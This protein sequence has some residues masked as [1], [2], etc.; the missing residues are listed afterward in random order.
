MKLSTLS[1][2]AIAITLPL[3]FLS[4][5]SAAGGNK[6]PVGT[7]TRGPYLQMQSSTGV[8]VRWRTSSENIG[9]I[10][11]GTQIDKLDQS[12]EEQKPTTEHE[13]AIKQLQAGTQYYYQVGEKN[14]PELRKGLAEQFFNTTP[15]TN[16]PYRVWVIGDAG[17]ANDEQVKV[18]DAFY[19][20]EAKEKK[21]ADFWLM[22]GDNA[23][24]TG[25]DQEYQKAVFD[26][27]P[28]I[29]KRSTLFSTRGNHE[30][31]R[32]PSGQAVYYDIFSFP[33]G[34]E[35]G[36]LASGTE[37][38][39]SFNYGPVHYVCLDSEGSDRSKTGAMAQ[40]LKKDLEN[41][42]KPWT[43][44]FWHHPPYTKGS[45]DSD[46]ESQLVE[47]RENFLPLLESFGV[48][49]VLSGHSHSYERSYFMNG[50]FGK[51]ETFKATTHIVQSGYGRPKQDAAYQKQTQ[52]DAKGTIYS[53][54]GSSGKISGGSLN[55]KAMIVSLNRLG[56]V[57]L[58]IQEDKIE[59]R[60]LRENGSIDDEFT[61][62]Q[63]TRKKLVP[64]K[65]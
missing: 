64:A 56:S 39:Y 61:I 40:W 17:T 10:F 14:G 5:T 8:S 15:T 47:M 50:H 46:R 20:L 34:N 12:F 43:I 23:Y 33:T 54:A 58:D 60:F 13:I 19:Q 21:Q 31:S 55:H 28:Q 37:A 62:Q 32:G 7:L 30:A 29:L 16:S 25:T 9:K 18:R 59:F 24:N 49:L 42:I 36:G 35:L 45:H 53:V 2:A 57:V 52:S 38:Y 44:A 41:N 51:S 48:D 4:F 6:P 65:N 1:K 11:Y 22:L 3:F 63:K 26:I 27:Y